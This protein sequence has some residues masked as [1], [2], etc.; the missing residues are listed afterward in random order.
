MI[1]KRL[2]TI[3]ILLGCF[4]Y[5]Y[6]QNWWNQQFIVGTFRD[7]PITGYYNASNTYQLAVEAGFNLFSGEIM[8]HSNEVVN[9]DSIN[10][11]RY[12]FP[13]CHFLKRSTSLNSGEQSVYDGIFY[14][15]EPFGNEINYLMQDLL[16]FTMQY[17]SKLF[18]V[19]LLP[20]YYSAFLDNIENYNFYLQLFSDLSNFP[21]FC[22]NHY[23]PDS[24][25]SDKASESNKQY[26]SNLALMKQNAGQRPFWSTISATERMLTKPSGWQK[27]YMRLSAF[28]PIAYGAKGLMYYCYDRFDGQV[29]LRDLDYR[30]STGWNP[31]IY[32]DLPDNSK[33]QGIFFGLLN[34]N[35]SSDHP[36]IAIKTDNAL[37]TWYLKYANGDAGSS[38]RYWSLIASDYGMSN[39]TIPFLTDWNQDGCQDIAVIL[40]TG[41]LLVDTGIDGWNI[42]TP[43]S[44]FTQNLFD[45]TCSEKVAAGF[46]NGNTLPDLCIAGEDTVHLYLDYQNGQ[47]TFTSHLA[48]AIAG[49]R[50]VM[51]TDSH[52][53]AI[54]DDNGDIRINKYA[55]TGWT[56][57][58]LQGHAAEARHF[59]IE[60]YTDSTLICMQATDGNL[61]FR[62]ISNSSP[63]SLG[64]YW[65]PN[66]T[67][68]YLLRGI[69]NKNG[70][71]DLY[72]IPNPDIIKD[73]LLEYK[74]RPTERYYFA[75]SINHYITDTIMPLLSQYEW[76]TCYHS[77][78]VHEIPDRDVKDTCIAFVSNDSW[79]IRDMHTNLMAGVFTQGGRT[80]LAIVN[81]GNHTLNNASI[82]LHGNYCGRISMTPRIDTGDN[83]ITTTYDAATLTTQISWPS[84]TGGE[85][86]V[87]QID[88]VIN[89]F[90]THR[91]SFFDSD[92]LAD[93]NYRMHDS[94]DTWIID[95][96]A[97]GFGTIDTSNYDYGNPANSMVTSS[98][99][100]GDGKTE[101][102][103]LSYGTST[104]S[105]LIENLLFTGWNQTINIYTTSFI[106]PFIGDFNGDGKYDF[107]YRNENEEKLYMRYADNFY[108]EQNT[109]GQYGN[110]TF[111][112]P[113]VGD[114]DMDGSDDLA[115]VTNSGSLLVD[116]CCNGFNGWDYTHQLPWNN[117]S[118]SNCIM[119]T[120]DFDGDGKADIGMFRK[121][122]KTWYFDL[123][124]N[125]FG[126]QD[127]YMSLSSYI[128]NISNKIVSAVATDYDGDGIA[129]L[130]VFVGDSTQTTVYILLTKEKFY[131]VHSYVYSINT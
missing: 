119:V 92:N 55:T 47:S 32:Y 29:V 77:Q 100:N 11:I 51:A 103:V 27:A 75:K 131:Q 17:P 23:Y 78:H 113:A 82:S 14:I 37:G 101:I 120:S 13:N 5:I 45:E 84:M 85:C 3:F 53:Y 128:G 31:S 40:K 90:H 108:E 61:Y 96:A 130:A 52:L 25:F 106:T 63:I 71:Y 127:S 93:I 76:N 43:L 123:T 69:K 64:H 114:Y 115:L 50:Q 124:Y 19:D 39:M 24:F 18:F 83:N 87:L 89:Y 46:F 36:D 104:Q 54:S 97:N 34:T 88:S 116:V 80:A 41:S 60:E 48:H 109:L 16:S 70:G 66:S 117:I 2:L 35:N 99:Y 15:D 125:S 126:S 74:Q 91:N 111:T 86:I 110:N 12:L 107:F 98:D 79:S 6:C 65:G 118:F 7:P 72:G 49:V 21:V 59:W 73:G 122:T 9:S 42:S 94:N 112:T 105:L 22:F 129:D 81:K 68:N 10:T 38:D 67:K 4:N 121:D 26:F 1:T 102:S 44:G 95:Y 8:A 33:I 57:K 62:D 20:S 58:L 56:D 28:A 30:T